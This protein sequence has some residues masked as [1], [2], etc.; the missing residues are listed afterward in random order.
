MLQVVCVQ[1]NVVSVARFGKCSEH[2]LSYRIDGILQRA[3]QAKE[4]QRNMLC[5]ARAYAFLWASLGT[6]GLAVVPTSFPIFCQF[7]RVYRVCKVND[8]SVF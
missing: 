5:A 8:G 3:C 4:C 6:S 7:I 1:V 2:V